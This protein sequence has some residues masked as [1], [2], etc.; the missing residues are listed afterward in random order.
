MDRNAFHGLL[1]KYL[2]GKCTEEEKVI[3]DKWYDLLDDTDVQASAGDDQ[4]LEDLEDR[5]WNKIHGD[6]RIAPD[7]PEKASRSRVLSITRA[8]RKYWYAAA[9]VIVIAGIGLL[10]MHKMPSRPQNEKPHQEVAG[11]TGSGQRQVIVL[12]DGSRITLATGSKLDYPTHFGKTKR[13]VYLSGE[14]FFEVTKDP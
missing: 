9:M 4:E 2:D 7:R 14:A 13:E 5:L 11:S 10:L 1:K 3:I 8:H 6:I 12:E